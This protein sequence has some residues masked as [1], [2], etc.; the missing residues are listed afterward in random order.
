MLNQNNRLLVIRAFDTVIVIVAATS[1]R[2][3]VFTSSWWVAVSRSSV[4]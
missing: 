4:F 2:F 1:V 3:G